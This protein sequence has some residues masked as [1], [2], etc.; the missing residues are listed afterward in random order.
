VRRHKPRAVPR[1]RFQT[2]SYLEKAFFFSLH[3]PPSP[4][5]SLQVLVPAPFFLPRWEAPGASGA[6]IWPVIP[7]TINSPSGVYVRRSHCLLLRAAFPTLFPRPPCDP[8]PPTCVQWLHSYLL[9]RETNHRSPSP[10]CVCR[11]RLCMR[12]PEPCSGV[13]TPPS[14]GPTPPSPSLPRSLLR[15]QTQSEDEPPASTPVGR[16]VWSRR[17]ARER[18]PANKKGSHVAR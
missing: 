16:D 6:T 15:G 14:R 5:H 1:T 12:A 9:T 4:P 8:R 10:G 11:C 2:P 13:P 18:E 17:H 7:V 3:L